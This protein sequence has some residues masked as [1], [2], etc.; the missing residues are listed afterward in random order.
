VPGKDGVPRGAKA[1]VRHICSLLPSN[2]FV[3]RNDVKSY[4]ASIDHAVLLALV[5]QRID[6]WGV[7]DLVRQYLYRTVDEN[8]LYTTVTRGIVRLSAIA[9]DGRSLSGTAGSK[10]GRNRI[11]LR[12]LHGRLGH[13]CSVAVELAACRW[14]RQ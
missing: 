9:R 12:P 7:L 14:D 6:D 8:C 3:F 5:R 1:A 11:D 10:D 2:Q 13:S 4:Y